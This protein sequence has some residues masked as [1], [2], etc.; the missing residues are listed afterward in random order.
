MDIL[1]TNDW[2]DY[3]KATTRTNY[4]PPI[5]TSHIES[6]VVINDG[7]TLVIGGIYKTTDNVGVGG[8]PWLQDIPL[9][10]WLFKSKDT[11]KTQKQIF[12]FVT[13]YI[14]RDASRGNVSAQ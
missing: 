7:D 10:G 4:A 14:V 11:N 9:L 3:S 1:A 5:S 2:A 12:I 13:P 6:K 8:V